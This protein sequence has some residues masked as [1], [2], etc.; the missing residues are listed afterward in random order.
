[1]NHFLMDK[2]DT[3][4]S[5]YKNITLSASSVYVVVL[6]IYLVCVQKGLDLHELANSLIEQYIKNDVLITLFQFVVSGISAGVVYTIIYTIVYVHY[7]RKWKKEHQSVW[8]KGTWL[9]IHDKENIRVG[10]VRIK[11]NFH[12]IRVKGYNFDPTALNAAEKVM[13]TSWHYSMGKIA[14]DSDNDYVIGYYS[15]TRGIN[16]KSG[17]HHLRIVSPRDGHDPVT[18]IGTFHDIVNGKD[19][20]IGDSLGNIYMCKLTKE[21]AHYK[22]LKSDDDQQ[23]CYRLAEIIKNRSED[24]MSES[25]FRRLKEVLEKHNKKASEINQTTLSGS[26]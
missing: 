24:Y 10:V 9:H 18:M 23:L 11:Q 13:E 5:H 26:K 1:M 15:A 16:T 25:Y 14:D 22:E 12:S 21:Q 8:I 3:T 6:S 2:F 7:C 19:Q 17:I 4:G 20:K